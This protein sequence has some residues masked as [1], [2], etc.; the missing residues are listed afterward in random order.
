M[1]TIKH[2]LFTIL[3][4]A[5]LA[6]SGLAQTTGTQVGIPFIGALQNAMSGGATAN[7]MV[8]S[9]TTANG[10]TLVA[11]SV[12]NPLPFAAAPGG[13][14]F[15]II[16]HEL[17]LIS[18]AAGAV[19]TTSNTVVVRR[20]TGGTAAPHAAGSIVICG[21]NGQFNPAT[22]NTIG[23]FM[24]DV[25]HGTCT[26]AN[27]QFLPVVVVNFTQP[28]TGVLYNCQV[29]N[30]AGGNTTMVWT[31]QTLPNELSAGTTRVCTPP[32]VGLLS[33]LTTFGIA[34]A[35]ISLGTSV[36]DAPGKW[37]YSTIEVPQTFLAAGVS[38]LKGNVDATDKL[39]YAIF[40][41][42]GQLLQSTATGG[43]TTSAAIG[44]FQDISF[45]ANKPLLTG[46][47]RY[48]IAYQANG[49]LSSISTVPLTPGASTA[50]FG[51]WTGLLGST[52]SG[53]TGT[54]PNN[55]SAFTVGTNVGSGGIT[56]PLNALPT[57]LITSAA[58]I[59]CIFGP[60]TQ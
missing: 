52:L 59:A 4:M 38:V 17:M 30:L 47:A 19:N 15:C 20:A 36:A 18:S 31:P 26:P 23:V 44:N 57:S 28:D 11:S 51:A 37:F 43:T 35:P 6:S 53:T 32:N 45:L 14:Q 8:L 12:S 21:V 56:N 40:R 7:V 55:L 60:S 5:G 34:A 10:V 2:I 16:D 46:P 39:I 27:N 3:L 1:K 13:Q 48:W 50:G 24:R 54:V 22:G 49:A 33:L 9:S 29:G 25:P 42:D 41:S 58:P